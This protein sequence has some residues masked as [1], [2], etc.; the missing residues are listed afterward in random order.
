MASL[1]SFCLGE[2]LMA[3][4][5]LSSGACKLQGPGDQ[6]GQKAA[7]SSCC[8]FEHASVYHGWAVPASDSPLRY[9]ITVL[10]PRQDSHMPYTDLHR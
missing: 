4:L 2:D 8:T 7:V 1:L 10:E 3:V 9:R 6:R 5:W